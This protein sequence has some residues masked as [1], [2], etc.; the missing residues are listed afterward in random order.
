M[1]GATTLHATL[2]SSHPL[3]YFV[4][5]HATAVVVTRYCRVFF[6]RRLLD[7]QV[8][9]CLTAFFRLLGSRIWKYSTLQ[10]SEVL[11]A[12]ERQAHDGGEAS[13]GRGGG[14]KRPSEAIQKHVIQALPLLVASAVV[15]EPSRFFN[16][17]RSGDRDGVSHGAREAE[18][19]RGT[20]RGAAGGGGGAR[21]E[22]PLADDALEFLSREI[23]ALPAAAR[24]RRKVLTNALLDI[25]EVCYDRC[26]VAAAGEDTSVTASGGGD[27]EFDKGFRYTRPESWPWNSETGVV[28]AG[29]VGDAVSG[30]GGDVGYRRR[31]RQWPLSW[32]VRSLPRWAPRLADAAADRN[33][34]AGE[35]GGGE[36]V[37][38]LVQ[39]ASK[40]V[41]L[42]L[43]RHAGAA[44]RTAICALRGG[45]GGSP[46]RLDEAGRVGEERE[47]EE[48][49]EGEAEVLPI[50]G[51]LLERICLE[52]PLLDVMARVHAA[53]FQAH[54]WLSLLPCGK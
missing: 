9:G 27:S 11:D 33:H 41:E 40:V 43:H 13:R 44:W 18:Y 6:C 39:R 31:R 35:G 54:G 49:E 46:S 50:F 3:L 42:V 51:P 24:L 8:C 25:L 17:G 16:D 45:P 48:N 22:T 20:E 15:T 47:E 38:D 53:V 7:R 29:G 52:L 14:K 2:S 36:A 26:P 5:R 34:L 30:G 1:R 4:Y 19:G 28:S 21:D 23:L 37:S 32:P 10:P 12:I